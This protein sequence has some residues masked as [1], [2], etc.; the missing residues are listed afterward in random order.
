MPKTDTRAPA[1]AALAIRYYRRPSTRRESLAYD[2]VPVRFVCR[3][4]I[5]LLCPT[6]SL[7]NLDCTG[8][9]QLHLDMAL[10][11]PENKISQS[12][13]MKS[14]FDSPIAHGIT[15]HVGPTSNVPN[16]RL[17]FLPGLAFLAVF[18]AWRLVRPYS[19]ARL[20]GPG[21]PASVPRTR[22]T[23]GARPTFATLQSKR[24]RYQ[25]GSLGLHD[26]PSVA[27]HKVPAWAPSTDVR[28]DD[29]APMAS[30]TRPI[31]SN[32]QWE[33][34]NHLVLVLFVDSGYM[35]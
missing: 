22:T 11:I 5:S 31:L 8:G 23:E 30:S 6:R 28:A 26:A 24:A 16:G 33:R 15:S 32:T 27:G 19:T 21:N 25:V 4:T 14:I 7:R 12:M 17:F 35:C 9:R 29:F 3:R 13:P 20:V 1:T 2:E 34:K 10:P 18:S